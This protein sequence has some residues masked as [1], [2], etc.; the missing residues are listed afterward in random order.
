M[1][2]EYHDETRKTHRVEVVYSF[3]ERVM[4]VV[5][6]VVQLGGGCLVGRR[7]VGQGGVL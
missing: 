4:K 5:S 2:D 1:N 7:R 3:D 6:L